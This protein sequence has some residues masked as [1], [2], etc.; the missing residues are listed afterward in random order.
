M[1]VKIKYFWNRLPNDLRQVIA[2]LSVSLMMICLSML[3]LSSYLSEMSKD[4]SDTPVM[5]EGSETEETNH[6]S[7][8]RLTTYAAMISP[9]APGTKD[10]LA[11][12][13]LPFS[14]IT[15]GIGVSGE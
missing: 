5:A 13:C 3:V 14:V 4:T 10:E 9:A 11:G 7:M 8:S 15:E 6:S 1:I 12:A 2:S